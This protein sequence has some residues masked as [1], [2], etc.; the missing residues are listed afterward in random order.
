VVNGSAENEEMSIEHKASIASQELQAAELASKVAVP[1]PLVMAGV[2]PLATISP[3]RAQG[4]MGMVLPP[5]ELNW[6]GKAV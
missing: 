6:A 3:S 5:I 4:L 1:L 2:V